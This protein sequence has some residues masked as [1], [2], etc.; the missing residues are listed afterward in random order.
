ML[1]LA[2]VASASSHYQQ[3][4]GRTLGEGVELRGVDFEDCT[5]AACSFAGALLRGCSFIECRFDGSNLTGAS[6]I[7]TR[8]TECVLTGCKAIG[9][10]WA[11]VGVSTLAQIPITFS[12]CQ[13]DDGWFAGVDARGWQFD[14]CSLR[15]ADFTS[16]D[17][18]GAELSGCELQGARFSDCDLRTAAVLQCTG[19]ALDPRQ[20]KVDG[21]RVSA[22]EAAQLL[23]V[24][25]IDVE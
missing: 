22:T 1:D 21:L 15:S 12:R 3:S 23:A 13:L 9:V 8:F 7:D 4:F 2:R 14:G 16:A 25:G 20:N 18:R 24:F 10:A 5:F 11:T 19:F 6:F 17:L